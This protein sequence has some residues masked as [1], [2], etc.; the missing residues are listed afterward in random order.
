MLRTGV[1]SPSA[2]ERLLGLLRSLELRDGPV[3]RRLVQ[4]LWH[5]PIL[6]Q[7]QKERFMLAG[8]GAGAEEDAVETTLNEV[9]SILEERLG[10]SLT[11]RRQ[12]SR[13]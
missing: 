9:V 11:P 8:A 6:M 3:D 7:W 10:G 13:I 12:G 1:F 2:A 5:M 4:L